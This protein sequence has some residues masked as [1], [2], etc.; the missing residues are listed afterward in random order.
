MTDRCESDARQH[1]VSS[2]LGDDLVDE[3]LDET[4]PASDPPSWTASG[5]GSPRTS[6]KGHL[7][8]GEQG[9]SARHPVQ[10][11]RPAS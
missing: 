5:L 9:R 10:G 4:F 6:R 8:R 1:Q 11:T 2:A 3:T 7:P